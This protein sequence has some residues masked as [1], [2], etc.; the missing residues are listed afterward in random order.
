MNRVLT[1]SLAVL[2]VSPVLAQ[3][4]KNPDLPT[5]C[6]IRAYYLDKDGKPADPSDVKAAVIFETKDGKSRTYPMTLTEP[7]EKAEVPPCRYLP[8]EGTPYRMAVGS[9]C[10]DASVPGGNTHYDKPF[11]KPLPVVIE[12]ADRTAPEQKEASLVHTPYFR[13][14]LNE[15]ALQEL[16]AVPYTDASIQ[17]KVRNETHKTKCFTTSNGVPGTVCSRV[18]DDLKTLEKQLQANDMASAKA[19]MAR[20]KDNVGAIPAN[21]A[22][23][24]ARKGAAEC[25]QKLDAAVQAGN[26][27]KALAEIQKLREHCEKC[28][29][30]VDPSDKSKKQ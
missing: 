3:E 12:P 18:G 30:C 21:T 16:T 8:I 23:E 20:L 9:I 15:Q 25:C 4:K 11:L 17:F 5:A 27:E 26:R 19:T 29:E 13:A 1:L 2:A 28:D 14:Y 22:N 7:K 6:E 24:N 10:T